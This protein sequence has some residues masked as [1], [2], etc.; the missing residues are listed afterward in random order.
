M[1]FGKDGTGVIIRESRTVSIGT[2]APGAALEVGSALS[3]LSDFRILKSEVV[4]T[5]TGVTNT[6]MLGMA[7]YLVDGDLSSAEFVS[8][9]TGQG[10]LGPN[11]TIAAESAMR[12]SKWVGSINAEVNTSRIFI[13]ENGGGLLEIAPRW[14]FKFQKAWNWIV[15]NHGAAPTTG[16]TLAI[17]AKNFGVWVR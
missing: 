14:T 13:N 15:F 11:D 3:L 9:L 10:P 1:G 4:A 2:L 12:F 17:K 5:M 6:D 16:A 7:L 8:S